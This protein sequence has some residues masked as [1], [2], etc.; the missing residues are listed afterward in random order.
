M[1]QSTSQLKHQARLLAECELF[2]TPEQYREQA[3]QLRKAY[4]KGI[5][6]AITKESDILVGSYQ[7]NV[8]KACGRSVGHILR[9]NR[10]YRMYLESLTSK[11]YDY[12]N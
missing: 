12:E 7:A 9:K 11:A 1:K 8:A 3:A 10:N 5:L 6:R 2:G 4:G